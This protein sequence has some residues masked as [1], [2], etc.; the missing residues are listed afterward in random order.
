M[1]GNSTR[2]AAST[3]SVES[4]DDWL[5]GVNQK[6]DW[7]HPV[8]TEAR[9][10]TFGVEELDSTDGKGLENVQLEAQALHQRAK[11]YTL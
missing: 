11:I 3:L 1:C 9:L 2:R 10:A 7:S 6:Q 5:P 4:K 8:C